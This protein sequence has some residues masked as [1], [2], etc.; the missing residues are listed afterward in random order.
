VIR[1]L[2]I[3]LTLWLVRRLDINVID[4][5]R[6]HGG[7]DAVQRGQRWE[8]FLREE[9]G[10]ADM[11]AK[12]RRG[13]FEAASA[14]GHRDDKRLYEFVVADRIARE[15]EREVV[16]IVVTGKAEFE[17]REAAARENSARILRAL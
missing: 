1:A 8:M 10:L 12:L 16:Q 13:Y 11:L 3:R 7:T 17:R 15:L 2:A 6:L 14:I 4:Q 5:E 9:G